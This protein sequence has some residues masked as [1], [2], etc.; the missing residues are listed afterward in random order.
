MVATK[1]TVTT[2]SFPSRPSAGPAGFLERKSRARS[3]CIPL[4]SRFWSCRL[5]FLALILVCLVVISLQ[6]KSTDNINNKLQL[7]MKSGK[8]TLGYKTVLRTL[9]NSKCKETLP[10]LSALRHCPPLPWKFEE[11]SQYVIMSMSLCLISGDSDIIKTTP[12][13]Q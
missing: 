5:L 1:K 3:C 7:V 9:R 10:C 11:S 8:Y 2:H 13:D 6:K 4:G 12:G